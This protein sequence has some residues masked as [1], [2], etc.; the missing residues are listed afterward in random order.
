MPPGDEQ[1][2]ADALRTDISEPEALAEKAA[3]GRRRVLERHD[4]AR[5]MRRLEAVYGAA[6]SGDDRA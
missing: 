6:V 3:A 4:P 2:W 1:A 5:Y